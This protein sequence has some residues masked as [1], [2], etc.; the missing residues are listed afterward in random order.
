MKIKIKPILAA[1]GL[2]AAG[3]MTSTTYALEQTWGPQ[4]RSTS[5]TWENP[6]DYVTFNSMKNNPFIGDE[7]NFVRVKEYVEG[8]EGNHVDN[9]TV[10]PGKEYEVWI[11]F[12]NN[13]AANLNTADGG[14]GIAQNVRVATSIPSKL[15]AGDSGIVRGSISATNANPTAVWDTA[16]LNAD[17]PVWLRYVPNSAVL[18]TSDRCNANG[19]V[20]G[21]TIFTESDKVGNSTE[22]GAMIS[23]YNSDKYWGLIPG[24]NEYAGYVTYRVK[25]DQPNFWM[26]KTVAPENS[27]NFVEWLNANPG[28]VF[29]FKIYYKNTGTTRQTIVTLRD[30]MPAGMTYTAGSAALNGNTLSAEDEAKLFNEGYV[31]GDY[32][33]DQEATITYKAQ[34]NSDY[35]CNG[36]VIYNDALVDT[37]NGGIY[38]KV[39]ITVNNTCST[40]PTGG[41][42]DD[43]TPS[44]LP[45][46]G[47]EQIIFASVVLFAIGV[48]VTYWLMSYNRLRKTEMVA[49]G[50]VG[51]S[52]IV[53]DGID[54]DASKQ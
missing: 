53:K 6:A 23:C 24:C 43:S 49:K 16:F 7:T 48:G 13:A 15:K 27:G 10:Q 44:E 20:L 31:I 26:E 41:T 8:E 45:K 1:L 9:V 52:D 38:D 40:T 30:I 17:T 47:P 3:A 37:G 19:T 11:Y 32:E 5:F 12:H 39:Q 51:N 35:D 22:V 33:P 34:I 36:G 46:T 29:D 50:G 14:K 4:D 42:T 28:D 54:N 25:A 2:V 18:H 21:D